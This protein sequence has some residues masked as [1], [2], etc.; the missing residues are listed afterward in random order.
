VL[1]RQDQ[2]DG[3]AVCVYAQEPRQ[4]SIR[5]H[6]AQATAQTPEGAT[7][8]A[9]IRAASASA[10]ERVNARALSIYF[11]NKKQNKKTELLRLHKQ[12]VTNNQV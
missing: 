10:S 11:L 6:R 3:V 8:G 12:A 2:A 7:G 5:A 1:E 9:G 4:I